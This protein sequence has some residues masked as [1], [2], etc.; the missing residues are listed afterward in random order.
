MKSIILL[1]LLITLG[2]NANASHIIG[3]EIYY[4]K[5]AGTNDYKITL[6]IYRDGNCTNCAYY[7]DPANLVVFNSFGQIEQELSIPLKDTSYVPLTVNPCALNPSTAGTKVQQG[8]YEY[9]ITLPPKIGGY[10][11]TYQRCCRNGGITNLSNP[12][13]EGATYTTHVPGSNVVAN[14]SSPRFT[15]LPPV[16]LC[17]TTDINFDNVATDPDGDV[18]VYEL[19]TPITGGSQATPKPLSIDQTPP[20]Y[21]PVVF[22]PQYNSQYPL[23]TSPTISINS[24]T[25][26]ITGIPTTAGLF[27]FAVCVKEYRNGVLLSTTSRDYQ[28]KVLDCG[29]P[30]AIIKPVQQSINNT[31]PNGTKVVCDG[32]GINFESFQDPSFSYNWDFGVPNI[33][34]DVANTP[35]PAYTYPDTGV[36]IIRLITTKTQV[37]T[38]KDTT[39]DTIKIERN[40]HPQLTYFPTG[41]QCLRNNS[42]NYKV[43][44][45]FDSASSVFTWDFLNA[46]SNNTLT[47]IRQTNVHFN[48]GGYFPVKVNGKQGDCIWTDNVPTRVWDP[49]IDLSSFIS[50]LPCTGLT[51][52][53]TVSGLD[54]TNIKWDFGV[55]NITTDVATGVS[56][57]YTYPDTG[58]YNITAIANLVITNANPSITCRDTGKFRVHVTNPIT[59][60][61]SDTGKYCTDDG[62][63]T[64][65]TQGANLTG[66]TFLWGVPNHFIPIGNTPQL[67]NLTFATAGDYKVNVKVYNYGCYAEDGV[68]FHMYPNPTITYVATP[69]EGC[70]PLKV[71]FTPTTVSEGPVLYNWHIGNAQN[72]TYTTQDVAHVYKD[73]GHF[74]TWVS[75]ITTVGCI[76]TAYD[77]LKAPIIVAPI[78]KASFVVDTTMKDFF[79]D[80]FIRVTNTVLTPYKNIIY[81]WGDYRPNTTLI[82]DTHY[83][84]RPGEFIISQY[85]INERGCKDTATI[86]VDIDGTFKFYV[87]NAF[88]PDGDGLNEVFLPK[89]T[90]VSEY[91]L[92]IFNRWGQEVF[93]TNT[94]TEGWNGSIRNNTAT[95][96]IPDVYVWKIV[97]R[98]RLKEIK[99]FAGT[100]TLLR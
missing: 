34:T 28:F 19:C 55:P 54:F 33:T 1:L 7:D 10:D 70:Q 56:V 99:R 92:T 51:H 18:L 63:V 97:V 24:T 5:I 47:G 42:F 95:Q 41:D 3:G 9:T 48:S 87:P 71:N 12:A 67:N 65:K 88:T 46:A 20:P 57:N 86:V 68:Q 76:D 22:A 21:T 64:F 84:N 75:L 72:T 61:V 25:G 78:P 15:N 38:C 13:S 49:K 81:N 98:D 82:N 62:S 17:L 43:I 40:F 8:V 90:G 94:I 89:T 30:V 79:D 52:P 31:L 16:F 59:I 74:Y 53:Y 93:I 6:K 29:L 58:T 83:Y 35:V 39:Y 2:L 36:Y 85:V 23:P 66:G 45:A 69:M 60:N 73:T 26:L 96:C 50:P 14:N 91:K 37:P 80:P 4:T 44:G 77:T 11:I 27:V 100:V 32:F